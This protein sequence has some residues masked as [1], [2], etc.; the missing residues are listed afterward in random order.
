MT[1]SFILALPLAAAIPPDARAA[2]AGQPAV[3]P[4][5]PAV[6]GPLVLH[7]SFPLTTFR[8]EIPPALPRPVAAGDVAADLGFQV[9][10]TFSVKLP[11]MRIDAE[12]WQLWPAVEVGVARDVSLRLEAPLLRR[13]AGTFDAFIDLYHD[14]IGVTSKA[15]A[16]IGEGG[17]AVTR[18][19]DGRAFDLDRGGGLGDARA[20]LRALAATWDD[21]RTALG[22]RLLG[23]FPTGA[24]DAVSSSGADAGA[25]L[26]LAVDLDVALLTA[27]AGGMVYGAPEADGLPFA[28]WHGM[29]GY[30]LDVPLGGG[31][32]LVG[33]AEARTPLL[34]VPGALGRMEEFWALGGRIALSPSAAFE[35]AFIDSFSPL[36]T[37]IDAGLHLALRLRF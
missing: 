27:T 21:G 16:V 9:G 35:F 7:D 25:A 17:Y 15:H 8:L 37:T 11:N 19:G 10:N 13:G 23:R 1:V 24:E 33:Q 12:Q 36:D 6:R 18:Q 14:A 26:D 29:G 22:A 20:E 31:V 4:P 28:R 32:S 34:E 30:S 5:S 2:P 3:P